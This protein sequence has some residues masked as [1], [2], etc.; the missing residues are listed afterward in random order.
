MPTDPTP[1]MP[2]TIL[3]VND[4][5]AAR[6]VSS[7]LLQQSGFDVIEVGTGGDALRLAREARPDLILLDVNLPDLDGFAVCRR[8][9]ADPQT[10]AIPVLHLSAS[11]I[12]PEDKA[13]GLEGGADGY[14]VQPVEPPELIAT[15]R[16]LLRLSRAEAQA[17]T[18]ARAWQA[19]FD[20]INDGVCLL[21]DQDRIRRCNAAF[22]DLLGESIDKLRGRRYAEAAA[23]LLGGE[24]FSFSWVR[25]TERR[26]VREICTPGGRWLRLSTD[27]VAGD[28]EGVPPGALVHLVADISE[29]KQAGVERERIL[30][31]NTRLLEEAAQAVARQRVFLR[32]VLRNVSE[33][34]L[35][36]C[37][38]PDE[39]PAPLPL[40]GAPV[41]LSRPTLRDL[42]ALTVAIAK[43][44]AF[45]A[46][47]WQDLITAVGEAAMNAVVHAANGEAR[48][49]AADNGPSNAVVQVWIT[50]AGRGIGLDYLHRATLE[51]GFTTAGTAG[52]GF[53]LIQRTCD[54]VY[55]LTGPSGTTVVLEQERTVPLPEWMRGWTG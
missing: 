9:K 14:L 22:A 2:A 52:M 55:L 25:Q 46:E 32:E 43:D 35:H 11:L 48:V 41:T 17:R 37:D 36:L 40:A 8:I 30:E 1:L 39:L 19:T 13:H 49:C 53:S 26:E 44:Y 3:N 42:R 16:A 21:D 51:P 7:R 23:G 34:R 12:A 28:E 33:G 4:D 18:A 15:V 20:A 45:P 24:D 54:R 5:E 10:A 50:D 47:R 38:R 31:E 27:L 29:Q 6:Y